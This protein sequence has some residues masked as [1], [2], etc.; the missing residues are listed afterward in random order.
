MNNKT[1]G[2]FL[3]SR[4]GYLLLAALALLAYL[5]VKPSKNNWDMIGY[6]ASAYSYQGI[7]GSELLE[8]TYADVRAATDENSFEELVGLNGDRDIDYRRAVHRD[9]A[10]LEQQTIP[11]KT[12]VIYVLATIATS[13]STDTMSAATYVVS[14]CAGIVALLLLSSLLIRERLI[15]FLLFPVALVFADLASLSR[16]ITP[17]ML[18]AMTAI[19]IACIGLRAPRLAILLLPLLPAVRLDYILMVPLFAWVL[20]GRECRVETIASMILA[21]IIYSVINNWFSN[22]DYLVHFNLGLIQPQPYPL[23]MTISHNINDYVGAYI[24]GIRELFSHTNTAI[25][26]LGTTLAVVLGNP[27]KRSVAGFAVA[28][29]VFAFLHFML[30]PIGHYRFY[31]VATAFSLVVIFLSVGRYKQP[32]CW[33]RRR[34]GG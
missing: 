4:V 12:R 11:Y 34:R 14:A 31:F 25:I 30:F 1:M 23:E 26:I 16:Y 20:Y 17:D 22:H 9:P 21:S 29:N 28:A 33:M 6:V 19:A 27:L 18:A 5:S 7:E 32:R 8:K 13:F 10:A 24:N 15:V 3:L 2:V